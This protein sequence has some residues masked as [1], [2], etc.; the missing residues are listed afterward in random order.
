MRIIIETLTLVISGVLA[1]VI[2]IA[3]MSAWDK[4]GVTH[5]AEQP[6]PRAPFV[7]HNAAWQ[8]WVD[9]TMFVCWRESEQQL[10]AW[11]DHQFF[12]CM[13]K[14]HAAI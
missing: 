2:V 3:A 7:Q 14:K 13:H 8:Q 9:Q 5:K 11:T 4:Y 10:V 6:E 12:E 1:A